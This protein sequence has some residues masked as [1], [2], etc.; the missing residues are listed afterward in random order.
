MFAWSTWAQPA[1]VLADTTVQGAAL[2]LFGLPS[3]AQ[4]ATV[5]AGTKVNGATLASFLSV[6]L[7]SA[8]H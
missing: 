4:P 8:I 6:G 7:G 1:I 2:H 5:E 3:W